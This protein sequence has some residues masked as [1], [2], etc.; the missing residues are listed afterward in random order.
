MKILVAPDSYK[1]TMS[2]TE[3]GIAMKR[4]LLQVNPNLDIVV[5]PMAD[6]GEGT[7]D[8][9]ASHSKNVQEVTLPVPGPLGKKIMSK[10]III[11]GKTAVIEVAEVLGLPLIQGS[12]DDVGNRTSYGL[13]E[14]IIKAL[15]LGIRKF[16]IGLG[17]SATNDGGFGM[18][19]AL[20]VKFL[21]Q[22]GNCLSEYS[23]DLYKVDRV[24][25]TRLDPRIKESD[26]T[27][28]SDVANPLYGERGATAIFG[29]QK[30]IKNCDIVNIDKSMEKYAHI[31]LK[32]FSPHRNLATK[33]GAGA[34]GGLGFALSLLGG[35]IV[36]G[37]SFIAKHLN[38][39]ES[40]KESHF[41]FTGEG[42]SDATT[43]SGK[44]PAYVAKLA[45][46]YNIPCILVSGRI[47][48]KQLLMNYFTKVYSLVDDKTRV[49]IAMDHP[50]QTLVNKMKKIVK[51][52]I[53][54][55]KQIHTEKAPAAIG[56]YSQAIEA[57]DFVYVSGQ[58]GLNPETREL[59][60]GI[61]AQTKQMME[62]AKIILAEAGLS[63]ADAVKCTIYLS[64]MD[65]FSIVNEI[66]ASYMEEPYPARVA[67]E[68]SR[69][70]NDGLV[71]MDV[72]AY[73]K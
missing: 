50:E 4:A 14:I 65:H 16:L 45:K 36:D 32:K 40:I 49:E 11:K 54:M 60:E 69:L 13:G 35:Q 26:F 52:T 59:E 64:S 20:G 27:I 24:Q 30:G 22:E 12:L 53:I 18:L 31:V 34:A 72:I 23:K 8:V 55:K 29:P 66:Y 5:K 44:A 41:V 43:I 38:L 7:L 39:E 48:K 9:L 2:Q 63:L 51:E 70:P 6:G 71:E 1:G 68:V 46:K 57:G 62:N 19:Q 61:E 17:G 56:P 37:A 10:F 33:K 67:I 47:E 3:A 58:L 42:K 21:D 25:L 28:M 73:K 15:D